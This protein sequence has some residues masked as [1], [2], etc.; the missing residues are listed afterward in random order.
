ME[1]IAVRFDLNLSVCRDAD[2]ETG[3]R[4]GSREKT[5]QHP[6]QGGDSFAEPSIHADL[7]SMWPSR[8]HGQARV[9][10]VYPAK[11]WWHRRVFVLLR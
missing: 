3:Q 2:E 10:L 9:H 6:S 7:L 1:A 5:G 11:P 4:P 8:P